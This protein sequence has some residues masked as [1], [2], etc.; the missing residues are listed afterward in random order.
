MLSPKQFCFKKLHKSE[1]RQ[2]NKKLQRRLFRVQLTVSGNMTVN[3]LDVEFRGWYMMESPFLD[4]SGKIQEM[5]DIYLRIWQISLPIFIANIQSYLLQLHFNEAWQQRFNLEQWQIEQ[6]RICPAEAT[7]WQRLQF[8]ELL[9]ILSL[10]TS[11]EMWRKQFLRLQIQITITVVKY[12][13]YTGDGKQIVVTFNTITRDAQ[14]HNSPD[15]G[16][17]ERIHGK[18]FART[19]IVTPCAAC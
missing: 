18:V 11:H 7:Q 14:H 3:T 13:K 16:I 9:S 5:Y 19:H 6:V 15:I 12:C 17:L 2:I 1:E 8:L 4:F 10:S